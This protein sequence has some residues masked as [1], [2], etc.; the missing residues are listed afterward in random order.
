MR[1]KKTRIAVSVFCGVLCLLLVG[2]WVRSYGREGMLFHIK[3]CRLQ[4]SNGILSFT[5]YHPDYYYNGSSFQ[6]R[7][8][9]MVQRMP[10]WIS[11]RGLDLY[12]SRG[13]FSLHLPY[14]WL[15]PIA[16]IITAIPW[17]PR[18]TCRF[19]LRTLFITITAAAIGLWFILRI[20]RR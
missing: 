9:K 11:S 13:L 2:L 12:L 8:G 17:M 18:P 4:S 3:H 20:A 16:V 7:T 10:K 15:T 14:K 6:S 5:Y 19:S 1:F